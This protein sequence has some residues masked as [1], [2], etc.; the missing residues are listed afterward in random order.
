MDAPRDDCMVQE[1]AVQL[2][3]ANNEG[4]AAVSRPANK[5]PHQQQIT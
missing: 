2:L 5:L 4:L 3:S 1:L